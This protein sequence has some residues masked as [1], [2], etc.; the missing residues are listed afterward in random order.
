LTP[1]VANPSVRSSWTITSL[2]ASHVLSAA[3]RRIFRAMKRLNDVGA[4]SM[5]ATSA[6]EKTS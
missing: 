1:P 2:G 4:P 5:P 6:G 3:M